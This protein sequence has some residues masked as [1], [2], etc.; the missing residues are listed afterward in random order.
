MLRHHIR[1]EIMIITT[2]APALETT[3]VQKQKLELK[4]NIEKLVDKRLAEMR[5]ETEAE[6]KPENH[7]PTLTHETLGKNF[8]ATA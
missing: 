8:D 6:L 5:K 3:D 1:E 4:A 7:Q 2:T